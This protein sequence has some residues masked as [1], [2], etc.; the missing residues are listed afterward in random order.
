MPK[1]EQQYPLEVEDPD[2][3]A[4]LSPDQVFTGQQL[5]MKPGQTLAQKARELGVTPQTLRLYHLEWRGSQYDPAYRI[6]RAGH[7]NWLRNKWSEKDWTALLR[8]QIAK[9]Q[10]RHVGDLCLELG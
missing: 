8:A 2:E 10:H 1:H 5:A 4:N 3:L 7:K 6:R 9:R